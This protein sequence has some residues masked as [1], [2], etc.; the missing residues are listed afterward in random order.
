M[1]TKG[2]QEKHIP[3]CEIFCML[4]RYAEA[5]DDCT[6]AIALDNTYSKAFARRG[7]AR[8]ALGNLS[9]AKAG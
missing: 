9:K 7:T 3:L 8:V 6:K 1:Q 5:E 4:S 2:S